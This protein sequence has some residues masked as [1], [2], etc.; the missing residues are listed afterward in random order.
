MPVLVIRRRKAKAIDYCKYADLPMGIYAARSGGGRHE[1][2]HS[3]KKVPPER[4]LV[5]SGGS[6]F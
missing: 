5:S 2:S 3:M 1:L 4:V 6:T